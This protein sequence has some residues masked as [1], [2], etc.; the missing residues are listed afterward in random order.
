M[1]K[2]VVFHLPVTAVFQETHCRCQVVGGPKSGAGKPNVS[3]RH[4]VLIKKLM[5]SP[6]FTGYVL[7]SER[8]RPSLRP[9]AM[10]P[11]R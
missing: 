10:V 9:W 2:G 7:P 8:S 5:M 3:G 6:S 4:Y 11:Q 1:G